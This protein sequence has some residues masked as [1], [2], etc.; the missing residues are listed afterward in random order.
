MEEMGNAFKSLL[1]EQME[2]HF[3]VKEEL[4]YTNKNLIKRSVMGNEQERSTME[5]ILG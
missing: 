2:A 4:K 5:E 3:P 1:V